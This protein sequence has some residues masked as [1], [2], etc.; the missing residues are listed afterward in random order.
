MTIG[1]ANQARIDALV[2]K[3]GETILKTLRVNCINLGD[4]TYYL[5]SLTHDVMRMLYSI[6]SRN[7]TSQEA[8]S[9]FKVALDDVLVAYGL[10]VQI[11]EFN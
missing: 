6:I 11:H 3:Q 5:C 8:K 1:Q 7:M 9:A 4:G 2:K 10:S